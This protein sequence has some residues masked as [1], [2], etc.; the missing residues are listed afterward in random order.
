MK[1]TAHCFGND[2]IINVKNA[3]ELG[4]IS[5]GEIQVALIYGYGLH[6]ACMIF[7]KI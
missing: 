7:K 4:K 5:P 2:F 6:L 3:D 1:K